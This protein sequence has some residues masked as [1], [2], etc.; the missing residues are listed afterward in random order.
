[1]FRKKKHHLILSLEFQ[2]LS[3]HEVL[4]PKQM[5]LVFVCLFLFFDWFACLYV[6]QKPSYYAKE[7]VPWTENGSKRFILAGWKDTR[8]SEVQ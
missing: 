5:S 4:L 2:S 1:M 8:N 3:G 6:E 7:I